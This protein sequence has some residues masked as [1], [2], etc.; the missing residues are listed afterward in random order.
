MAQPLKD[1]P[2]EDVL[3][4]YANRK[5]YDNASAHYTSNEALWAMVCRGREY[6]VIQKSDGK[7][8]S[9]EAYAKLLHH[10]LTHKNS[11]F[12]DEDAWAL[13]QALVKKQKGK[14]NV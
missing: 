5:V 8:V 14:N 9:K 2:I 6:R 4:R 3:V 11:R 10:A 7:D 13:L 1:M 12:T